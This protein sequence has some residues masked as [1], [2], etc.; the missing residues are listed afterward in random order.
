MFLNR[1]VGIYF[2]GAVYITYFVYR[3]SKN[4]KY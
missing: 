3:A 2:G 1:L 4:T